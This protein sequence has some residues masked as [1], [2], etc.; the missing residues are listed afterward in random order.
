ML[1]VLQPGIDQAI[2]D[3]SSTNIVFAHKDSLIHIKM[4][5]KIIILDGIP[6]AYTDFVDETIFNID[7]TSSNSKSNYMSTSLSTNIAGHDTSQRID[8]QQ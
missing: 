3:V 2:F 7:G 6:N 4:S 5:L 1:L 8:F